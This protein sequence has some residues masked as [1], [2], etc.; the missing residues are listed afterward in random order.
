MFRQNALHG[1][2]GL[3]SAEAVLP[4][5]LRARLEQSWAGVFYR[6][7]F[8]RIDERTFEPLF[9]EKGSRPNSAVNVLVGAEV[10]KSG[11][12]WSDEELFDHVSFDLQVRYGL[13][14]RDLAAE[15]FTLR[16]LYNFRRRVREHADETGENLFSRVMSQVTDEQL[17]AHSVDAS[18]QRVDSTQVLTGIASLSRIELVI[19]TVQR[20]YA[21]IDEG[22]QPEWEVR[23]DP[24]IK[25]R[26][27]RICYRMPSSEVK[28]HL[29][30]LGA[31]LTDLARLP[32]EAGEL[33]RRLFSEQ[34]QE[35]ESEGEDGAVSL[36]AQKEVRSTSL[37]SPYDEE[38]TYRYK[39]NKGHSGYVAAVAETC[40]PSNP[41][42]LVTD[43]V[44]RPNTTDD[45]ALL[46]ETLGQ[47]AERGVG[48][49]EVTVDGGFTGRVGEAACKQHGVE[50]HPTRIRGRRGKAGQ[51]GWEKYTWHLDREGEAS[52]VSCPGGETAKLIA[53]KKAHVR[54]FF[55][56]ARCEACPFGSQ[57]RVRRTRRGMRLYVKRRSIEVA[58][59][60]QGQ[61]AVDRSVRAVVESTVK[62]LKRGLAASKLPVR[63]QARATMWLCA[64]AMM[65][66]AR[67]LH[68]WSQL[69][70]SPARQMSLKGVLASARRSTNALAAHL[71]P[72]TGHVRELLRPNRTQIKLS[73]KRGSLAPNPIWQP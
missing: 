56:P 67:R 6:E 68:R 26:A 4:E 34:Y 48:V 5:K 10:L 23:L 1:Q 24:Y 50:M 7:V 14:L 46:E 44:T 27:K 31:L 11:Y 2:T 15:P 19:S 49:E 9:S 59:M 36:L 54:A 65:I 30:R 70:E 72:K 35:G 41:V 8:C 43:I 60:R 22:Q 63:G 12:G 57:C 45:G 55:N 69:Q 64:S 53:G 52:S 28:R 16:T 62:S 37:Q 51:F 58:I 17:S 47:Q 29:Q 73:V 3:F 32:G 18:W 42:Q 66:N 13:G 61:R 71:S 33:A 20:I 40:A 38:A 21:L 25:D 39:S